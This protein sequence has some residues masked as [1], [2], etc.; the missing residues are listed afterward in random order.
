MKVNCPICNSAATKLFI[1]NDYLGPDS[2][3][4]E[5]CSS[6][7][8]GFT[9]PQPADLNKYYPDDYRQFAKFTRWVMQYLYRRHVHQW[10]KQL[11][12]AGNAL[13]VGCGNGWMLNALS[14]QGWKV[15]GYERNEI[16]ANRVKAET[17]HPVRFGDLGA[18]RDEKFDLILLFNV[19]EHLP[20][21]VLVLRQC[22]S[23]LT[24][25]GVLIINAP[26]LDSWQA[27]FSKAYWAHL[28]VPRHLFH[29]SEKSFDVALGKA[30]LRNT[31][32][33]TVSWIHDP[34]GWVV[35]VLNKL[36]FG[37]NRLTVELMKG[38]F[39]GFFNLSGVFMV[40][41]SG[42][43]LPFA[44]VASLVSWCFG[45]GALIEVWA[46]KAK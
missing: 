3:A 16:Q 33:T 20:D 37:H 24:D 5:K 34:Y 12:F 28:D 45:K 46:K 38:T 36:G 26:N 2:F 27:S 30:G 39:R 13:E 32:V 7:G 1:A 11:G 18:I 40:L 44:V 41:V 25:R 9:S 8:V 19:I 10:I 17:G 14:D 15:V 21:P 23:L 43:L 4:V 6:C 42:L 22:A 31:H 29:F 35:G